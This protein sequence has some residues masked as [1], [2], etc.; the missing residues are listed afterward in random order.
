MNYRFS[1]S[2]IVRQPMLYRK[3]KFSQDDVYKLFNSSAIIKEAIYLASPELFRQLE[4][5]YSTNTLLDD[6]LFNSLLKYLNRMSWRSTPFGLFATCG[7]GKW[8]ESTM[9][10]YCDSIQ[11]KSR[12][13]MLYL[14]DLYIHIIGNKNVRKA[15]NFLIN[16]SLYKLG[17]NYRYIEYSS[18]DGNRRYQITQV[19]A[20]EELEK[21]LALAK[22]GVSYS[23]LVSELVSMG[24][25]QDESEDFMDDCIVSQLLVTDFE[26]GVTCKDNFSK[27]LNA[28]SEV[29]DTHI[30]ELVV[31]LKEAKVMLGRLDEKINLEEEYQTLIDKLNVS[32]AFPTNEKFAIQVDSYKLTNEFVLN[33]YYQDNISKAIEVLS[34]LAEENQ[35]ADLNRFKIEFYNR[36]GDQFVPLVEVLDT[37]FGLGYPTKNE[38]GFSDLLDNIPIK[39]YSKNDFKNKIEINKRTRV[40]YDLLKEA[41]DKNSQTISITKEELEKREITSDPN[42]EPLSMSVLA[43]ILKNNKISIEGVSGTSAVNILSRFGSGSKEIR[44]LVRE[45]VKGEEGLTDHLILSEILHLPEGRVGNIILHPKYRN[46]AINFLSG[47][48]DEEDIIPITDL[49]IGVRKNLVVLKSRSKNKVVIPRLSNSHNY[50]MHSLPIYHFLGDLQAQINKKTISFKWPDFGFIPDF[51]PQVV[52]DKVVISPSIWN[53]P[54]TILTDLHQEKI[55]FEDF[56]KEYKIVRY[57]IFASGDNSLFIDLKDLS[58]LKMLIDENRKN[59]RVFLSEY[60][61]EAPLISDKEHNPYS[62]QFIFPLIRLKPNNEINILKDINSTLSQHRETTVKRKFLPGDE[63]IYFKI[64]GGKNAVEYIL[65]NELQYLID[66]LNNENLIN[67]WFFIRF[68]DTGYHFRLRL[69]LK[70]SKDTGTVLRIVHSYLNLWIENKLIYNIILD[71]YDRETERYLDYAIIDCEQIFWHDS[72][73]IVRYLS[74]VGKEDDDKL[75]WLFAIKSIDALLND[76]GMKLKEKIDFISNVSHSFKQEFNVNKLILKK[77]NKKFNL[78][79][80][81]I[82]HFIKFDIYSETLLNERSKDCEV[83]INK[84][85]RMYENEFPKKPLNWLIADFT[86]MLL[87]RLYKFNP[88]YHEMVT[89]EMLLNYYLFVKNTKNITRTNLVKQ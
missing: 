5:V 61:E 35:N 47:I 9:F 78:T 63:W 26:P 58:A 76:F 56:A 20:S 28:L 67:E 42:D 52:V 40:F 24:Y 30:Q 74:F 88:R 66:E 82:D 84:I 87:N 38:I 8:G 51:F 43:K 83:S 13:D 65:A 3:K 50:P 11:R 15:S 6:K 25:D 49:E 81:E 32:G 85:L 36:Y 53:I 33:K 4:K 18:K 1:D 75:R 68:E 55:T 34:L 79:K 41:K 22:V 10:K 27:I 7:S 72:K 45:I 89:Y 16:T 73:S 12:L 80:K 62:H 70:N 77:I 57:V 54:L 29:D 2:F 59:E 48:S 64:Y 14:S 46:S 23:D 60:L 39:S 37:E 19:S 31:Q 21:I 69:H 44:N 86:H 71:G 17:K